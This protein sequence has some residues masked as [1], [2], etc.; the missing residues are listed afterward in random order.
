MCNLIQVVKNFARLAE[1][2]CVVMSYVVMSNITEYCSH[3]IAQLVIVIKF[4]VVTLYGQKINLITF[5]S[6]FNKFLVAWIIT[7]AIT[8]G[9]VPQ[10]M[11]DGRYLILYCHFIL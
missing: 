8:F 1:S 2:S 4:P 9:F 5:R 7:L 10:N 6:H 11:G 3:I